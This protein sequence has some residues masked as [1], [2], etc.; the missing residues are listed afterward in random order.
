MTML[1]D[2][3]RAFFRSLGDPFRILKP[4]IPTS[5]WW[6]SVLILLIP[7]IT[8]QVIASWVFYDRH[9]QVVTKR[10]AQALGSE[11]HMVVLLFEEAE[12]DSEKQRVTSLA[13]HTMQFKIQEQP[14]PIPEIPEQVLISNSLTDLSEKL[15]AALD[16]LSKPF[17]IDTSAVDEEIKVYV[18]L[19]RSYL[20]V[21]V[22]RKRVFTNTFYI[23]FFWFLFSGFVLFGVAG[24][25]WRNQI[26]P[27]RRLAA[28]A[29][30][31]AKGREYDLREEGALEVRQAA[32]AF[33][34]MRSSLQRQVT[35]RTRML[36]GVS[37]DLRTPLTRIK[38]TLAMSSDQTSA[39][40]IGSD[41]KDMESMIDGYLRFAKGEGS[42]EQTLINL[43][44]LGEEII[45]E[46]KPHAG[47]QKVD[48]SYA[49][50][51]SGAHFTGRQVALK[52]CLSNLVNNAIR[53][54]QTVSMTLTEDAK[55]FVF[56]VDDDG[57][58]IPEAL[59]AEVLQPFVR[60]DESRNEATGGIGLGLSISNEVALS[61]GGKLT[62]SDS[63]LG[64][65]RASVY[66]PK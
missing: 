39:E 25:F 27:I 2:R 17:A 4:L 37:H 49:A 21:W 34:N 22:Q 55:G 15:G 18:Q 46:L 58:G 1:K 62:L 20:E 38:L 50:Q 64:G 13:A 28:A 31:F 35:Q 12:L 53:F 59:R 5:L 16:R 7:L 36:A 52:R 51:K 10:L 26:R 32:N 30:A 24:L 43:V 11:I 65:L 29:Q 14:G 54:S 57:P 23:F 8:M 47:D 6:R 41:I 33:A 40:A 63:P 42:E 60:V 66:L 44:L 45:I 9:W 56:N 19:E 48:L 61:H 3:L